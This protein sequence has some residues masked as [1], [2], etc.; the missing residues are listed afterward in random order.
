MNILIRLIKNNI[1]VFFKLSFIFILAFVTLDRL[2]KYSPIL[3][4]LKLIDIPIYL[5][6]VGSAIAVVFKSI[7]EW[8]TRKIETINQKQVKNSELINEN[9]AEIV[10]SFRDTDNRISSVRLALNTFQPLIDKDAQH[11]ADLAQIR[12]DF[13]ETLTQL[14]KEFNDLLVQF[15]DLKQRQDQGDR[16][17]RFADAIAQCLVRQAEIDTYIKLTQNKPIN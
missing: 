16:L 13:Q 5:G 10:E 7:K 9:Y 12:K 15:A 2:F 3:S 4:L 14:R 17:A 8:F 6:F 1:W 11:D